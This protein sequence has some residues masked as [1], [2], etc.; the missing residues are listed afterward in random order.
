[1]Q[2]VYS[3]YFIL[4]TNCKKTNPQTTRILPHPRSDVPRSAT[5]YIILGFFL[6]QK[7][8]KLLK[9]LVQRVS[10]AYQPLK[11]EVSE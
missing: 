10:N 1:M 6:F 9:V 4:Y 5:D 11:K 3:M 2:C 7:Q 8:G